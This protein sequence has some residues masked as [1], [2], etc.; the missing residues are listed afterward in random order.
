MY[1]RQGLKEYYKRFINQI[2]FFMVQPAVT[3]L[4]PVYNAERFLSEAIDS[5]LHQTFTN[6]ELRY[7][8]P[9]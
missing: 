5:I 6:F 4:M 2:S 7:G 1:F 9:V 3:V 8:L